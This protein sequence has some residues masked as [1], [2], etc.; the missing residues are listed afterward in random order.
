MKITK[1]EQNGRVFTLTFTP[2]FIER[3]FG[4]KEKTKRFRQ[5][6]SSYVFGDGNV[7]VNENGEKLGNGNWIGKTIDRHQLKF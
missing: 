5:T 6:H 7:Y 4:S 2:T 1:I 3:L